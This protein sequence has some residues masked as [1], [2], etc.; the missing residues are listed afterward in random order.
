MKREILLNKAGL[1]E[2]ISLIKKDI[3]DSL[4][5]IDSYTKQEVDTMLNH[6]QNTLIPGKDIYINN[7]TIDNEHE[8]FTNQDIESVWNFIMNNDF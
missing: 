2:L 6:K 3:D 4:G 5:Q 7:N 1:E 8:F